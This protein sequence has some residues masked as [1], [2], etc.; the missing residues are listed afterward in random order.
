MVVSSFAPRASCRFPPTDATAPILPILLT[1]VHIDLN[2][3]IIRVL[4]LDLRRHGDLFVL[5]EG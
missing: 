3:F 5:F 2:L 1:L 4:N